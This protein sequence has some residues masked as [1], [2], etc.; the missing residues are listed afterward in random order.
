MDI[1]NLLKLLRDNGLEDEQIKALL[2]EALK[3]FE[4]EEPEEDEE[5][6]TS[7]RQTYHRQKRMDTIHPNVLYNHH[8]N[9]V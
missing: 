5:M 3:S 8:P 1:E 6:E 2:E 9:E 4:T 7:N